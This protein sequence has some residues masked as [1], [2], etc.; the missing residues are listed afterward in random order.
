MSTPRWWS[1]RSRCL[2]R[3]AARASDCTEPR[4]G[5]S[6]RPPR[7][8]G[9]STNPTAASA[10]GW[11]T[12]HAGGFEKAL[13]ADETSRVRQQKLRT[14][15]RLCAPGSSPTSWP[16]FPVP[17]IP[18]L[19]HPARQVL[20]IPQR[21]YERAIVSSLTDI[22][23]DALL[24]AHRIAPPGSA[25]GTGRCLLPHSRRDFASPN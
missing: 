3:I 13:L 15:G 2:R 5:R 19:A 24:Q 20:A 17:H 4:R 7:R 14:A 22:E 1:G 12:R 6:G 25:A 9:C 16:T 23:V 21:R 8:C 11:T 10:V 18:S